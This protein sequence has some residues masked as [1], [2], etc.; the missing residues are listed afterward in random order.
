MTR[1]LGMIA[2]L[3]SPIAIC[4]EV[5]RKHFLNIFQLDILPIYIHSTPELW[6]PY[7][8]DVSLENFM[9]IGFC[10]Q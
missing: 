10:I 5:F 7:R 8:K 3:Y 6:I 9:N 4:Q 1:K 2:V